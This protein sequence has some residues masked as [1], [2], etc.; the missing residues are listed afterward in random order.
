MRSSCWSG[1]GLRYRKTWADRANPAHYNTV[2]NKDDEPPKP[3]DPQNEARN[4]KI[5]KFF[6]MS[7]ITAIGAGELLQPV[8]SFVENS[9]H[10]DH[11][12]TL[13]MKRWSWSWHTKSAYSRR[14]T[15]GMRPCDS[16][17]RHHMQLSPD[18]AG[19]CHRDRPY[20]R[21]SSSA[22]VHGLPSQFIII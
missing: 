14:N 2:Y 9:P 18:L 13:N 6:C 8:Q 10:A 12:S 15:Q 17:V 16:I 22:L 3:R 4:W 19:L 5:L 21:G 7:L 11:I 1:L 20:G